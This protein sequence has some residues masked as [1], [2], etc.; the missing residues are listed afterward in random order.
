MSN[1]RGSG[2]VRVEVLAPGRSSRAYLPL[3]P[4]QWKPY[5]KGRSLAIAL[6]LF[7]VTLISSLATG[8]QFAA[9][10][11]NNQTISLDDFF[12]FYAAIFTA[13]RLLLPGIPFALTLIGILL[14]HEL[15]HWFACRYHRIHA[16]YPYFIP[17]PTLIC[18]LA[19]FIN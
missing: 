3:P 12:R 1:G 4:P 8:A 9:A 17:A 18:T 5:H 13:P 2:A 11:A 19:A 16:S 6:A 14:A 15:G 7:V 10:Y